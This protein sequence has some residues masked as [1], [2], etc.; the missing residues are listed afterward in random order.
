MRDAAG[1]ITDIERLSV[2]RAER[3]LGVRLAPDGNNKAE[4]HFQ[5]AAAQT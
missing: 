5:M 2:Q 3:T 4:F 1:S